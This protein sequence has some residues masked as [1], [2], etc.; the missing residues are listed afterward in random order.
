MKMHIP[1]SF[2]KEDDFRCAAALRSAALGARLNAYAPYSKYMVGAAI[3]SASGRIFTG[4]NVESADYDGTHAEEAALVRMVG[5]G[6]RSPVRIMVFGGLEGAQ[7]LVSVPPCG[8][9]RQKLYEFASLS[10]IDLRILVD[11]AR[12]SLDYVLLLSELLRAAFGPADIGV[13]LKKYR[14]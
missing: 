13:D 7:K 2:A 3:L 5:D 1:I 10:D 4:C 8:K 9:C 14:R 6:E 12:G 11:D